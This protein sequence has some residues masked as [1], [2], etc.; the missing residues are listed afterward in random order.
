ML[1]NLD[2]IEK[3]DNRLTTVDKRR[4]IYQRFTPAFCPWLLNNRTT[5]IG[6][7]KSFLYKECPETFRVSEA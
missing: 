3:H 2:R 6:I 4:T 5:P 7:S 1:T